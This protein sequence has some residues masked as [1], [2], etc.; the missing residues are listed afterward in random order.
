[1]KLVICV[2]WTVHHRDI[3]RIISN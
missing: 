2:C 1:M 3:W